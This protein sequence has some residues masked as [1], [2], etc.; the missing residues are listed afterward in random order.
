[1]NC[2]VCDFGGSSVK[3]ALVSANA[4]I[5]YSGKIPAPLAS[6][7]AF[8]AALAGLYRRFAAQV[9][10]IAL[11][12]PGLID[13]DSGVHHGSGAYSAIL[14]GENIPA[15]VGAACGSVRVAVENDGKCGALAEA[16]HGAL[17][18]VRDGVVLILGTGIGGG[19]ILDKKIHRGFQFSAGEFSYALT[20]PASYSL[21][22][23]AMMNSAAFGL[24]YKSC[25]Y[26]NLSFASQDAGALLQKFDGL[27]RDHFPR[28]DTEG[29]PVKADGTQFFRWLE[30]G[31]GDAKRIYGEFLSSLAI[32]IHNIQICVAPERIVIGGGLSIAPRLLGDLKQELDAL[33]R[34]CLVPPSAQANVVRS[35]YLDECNL[36][37]AMYHYMQK[38]GGEGDVS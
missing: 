35:A 19:V 12:M 2:L 31:D 38:F 32:L 33:Y 5:T 15:L 16:W 22:G 3:Y 34:G 14:R 17:A 11:S 37:G 1:M 8:T 18:D 36:L 27:L 25:K 4:E 23:T 20:A 7:E 26:K 24:T 9:D 6:K 28:F 10:G 21:L 29:A 13:A 30:E